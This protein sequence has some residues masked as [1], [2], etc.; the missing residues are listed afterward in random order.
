MTLLTGEADF[1]PFGFAG[2]HYDPDTKLV[3]FGARDY[4][5]ETGRWTAKDPILFAGAQT[6]LYAYVD[7][8]PVNA[9]DPTGLLNPTKFGVGCVNSVL[10]LSGMV[11]G[12]DRIAGGGNVASV[13]WGGFR[14]GL[15][16]G[17]L[18]RGHRQIKE[19]LNESWDDAQW[20]NLWGLAPF[21]Q[22]YDDPHELTAFEW[23]SFQSRSF[24]LDPVG[25]AGKLARKWFDFE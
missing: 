2:G 10:G 12:V 3:R 14:F 24:V 16:L 19:A 21:G 13:A 15:G 22:Y 25:T 5:P 1:I 7:N 8:D 18:A 6:N 9:V 20:K 23:V 4:D 17:N 11:A